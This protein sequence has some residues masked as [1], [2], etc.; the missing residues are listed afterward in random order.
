MEEAGCMERRRVR[1]RSFHG[2]IEQAGTSLARNFRWRLGTLI[3]LLTRRV[4]WGDVVTRVALVCN[5]HKAYIALDYCKL[6]LLYFLS[7]LFRSIVV[8]RFVG[9][10]EKR[11]GDCGIWVRQNVTVSYVLIIVMR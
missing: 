8:K 6:T 4:K 5:N 2:R 1:S 3:L 10:V 9:S 7:F 11:C